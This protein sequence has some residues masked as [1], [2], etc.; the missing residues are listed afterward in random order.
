MRTSSP[1]ALGV[2]IIGLGI[3]DAVGVWAGVSLYFRASYLL[4]SLLVLGIAALNAVVL[5]RKAYPFR[6]L[7]P[8]LV[9]LFAMVLYPIFY[10]VYISFTNLQTG[11]LLSKEQVLQQLDE[12]YYQPDPSATFEYAAY[13]DEEDGVLLILTR[14][15][16]QRFISDGTDLQP[17][18]ADDERVTLDAEGVVVG[19][20]GYEL[21]DRRGIYQLSERLED[22]ALPYGD[23]YVRLSG[24]FEFRVMG[25]QYAYDEGTGVLTDLRTGT[26]YVAVDGTF[27]AEDGT[28]IDPGYQVVVGGRNFTRIFTNPAVRKDFV[29]V[30]VWT[31]IWSTLSV[32]ISFS[33]GL[34]FALLLNDRTLRFRL[35]Y[36]TLLIVPYIMPMFISAFVWRGMFNLNF[37][38][39]NRV[40]WDLFGVKVDWLGDPMWARAVLIFINV[41][42][43][44]PYMMLISLGALQSIPAQ[45]YEAARVDGAGMVRRFSRITLPLLMI[46]LAPLL[47]GAFAF[48]FNNFTLIW[49]VT[50]GRPAVLGAA[51]PAGAT[52][53]LIS[54]TYRIAFSGG[55]GNEYGFA[56]A[57]SLIIFF[58]IATISAI[59]FRFTKGLEE[60][61]K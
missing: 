25:K 5:S 19:V 28:T 21:V 14:D 42:L 37:G 2:R 6:Y 16:G 38:L 55:T 41:W 3:I 20:P 15:D 26:P 50:A 12:R 1:F 53:I 4:L 52:D 17:L 8:G 13:L 48:A 61:Y 18:V 11:N 59:G 29:R 24:I 45:L 56:S 27:T 34:S 9:F 22:L 49:L 10:T 33:L 40:L 51:T 44:F 43:T 60:V 47:I 58:I 30:F 23:Q 46:S 35:V 32:L 39:F 31:I 54:W 57:I 36:R 7:L